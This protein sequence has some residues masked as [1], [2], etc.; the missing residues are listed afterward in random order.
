MEH[1]NLSWN[2]SG[3]K[4]DLSMS[5]NEVCYTSTLLNRTSHHWNI[6]V[7]QNFTIPEAWAIM[8]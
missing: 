6:A 8:A 3:L 2:L 7:L 1:L 4:I 5:L